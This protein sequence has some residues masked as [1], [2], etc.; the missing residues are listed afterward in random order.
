MMAAREA[1][2]Q[3][4]TGERAMSN[5]ETTE[6]AAMI[7]AVDWVRPAG[8]NLVAFKFSDE[9]GSQVFVLD[10]D[11]AE[12]LAGG[13]IAHLPAPAGTQ[14]GFEI[15]QGLQGEHRVSDTSVSR[16]HSPHEPA[17]DALFLLRLSVGEDKHLTL[18]MSHRELLRWIGQM[19]AQAAEHH[20]RHAN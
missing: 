2:I 4:S 18:K 20:R 6:A 14:L 8:D 16:L 3:K 10:G 15:S 17:Q 7:E 1:A 13:L 19:Q 11:Q 9:G 5:D 12:A